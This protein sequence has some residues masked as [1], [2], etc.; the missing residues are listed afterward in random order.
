M[1]TF[2]QILENKLGRDDYMFLGVQGLLPILT[3]STEEYA[4]QFKRK[5]ANPETY[6]N[7][8]ILYDHFIKQKTGFPPKI[9]G[10]QGKSLKASITYFK[11]LDKVK[12]GT[13]TVESCFEAIFANWGKLDNFL[14]GQLKLSQINSNLS[15]IL[16]QIKNGH[17]KT[18]ASPR[19]QYEQ[20]MQI[21]NN[22]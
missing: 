13:H 9:D 8:M 15:L 5:P 7:C 22:K 1:R 16:N 6:Q 17:S 19:E 4:A 3:E 21:L 14:Q 11:A 10:Q 2:L 12:D 18:L 20:A